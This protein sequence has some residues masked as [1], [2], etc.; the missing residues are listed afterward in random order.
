M[1]KSLFLYLFILAVVL[2]IFTYMYY[3]QQ[4][5]FEQKQFKSTNTR[6]KDSLAVVKSKLD[7]AD[8]FSLE[9][10]QNAQDY[11]EGNA[12]GETYDKIIPRVSDALK[13]Y[14]AKPEGNPYVGYE[15]M[16]GKKF[17]INKVKVL[18]HRWII[19][20]FNNGGIWGEAI[21]KYFLNDDGTVSFETA[22]SVLYPKN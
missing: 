7:E 10:N 2:N 5:A 8:Y 16:D 20:D 1:K 3:S 18:N 6:L 11:F 12:S 21:I 19:A 22:E 15:K 13:E 4:T 14:N 17:L 9:T